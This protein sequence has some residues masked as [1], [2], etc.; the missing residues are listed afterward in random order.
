MNEL[1]RRLKWFLN[2]DRYE[3]EMEEE[4]R[5]HI[6]LKICLH[7]RPVGQVAPQFIIRRAAHSFWSPG[8]SGPAP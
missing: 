6:A 1:W 3:R 8:S 4:I 7:K 2:R 5:F